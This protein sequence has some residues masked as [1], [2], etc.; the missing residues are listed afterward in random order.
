MFK[1]NPLL[2]T[3]ILSIL[4]VVVGA[5]YIHCNSS[6]SEKF[7]DYPIEGIQTLKTIEEQQK[8]NNQFL[9]DYK[10]YKAKEKAKEKNEVPLTWNNNNTIQSMKLEPCLANINGSDRMTCYSAPLWWY[11]ETKYD[12]DNFRSVYYGDYYNPIYNFLGNAQEMFWDF[13]NVRKTYDVI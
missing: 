7:Q 2:I 11:P 4:I 10:E 6:K 9:K 3:L 5:F 12:P 1:L 8:E 13:R